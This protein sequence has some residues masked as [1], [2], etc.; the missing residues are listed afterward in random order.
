[1]KHI[2][3]RLLVVGAL[4]GG[5]GFTVLSA[6]AAPTPPALGGTGT[7]Q[8]PAPGQ[9]LIG[10]ASGTYTPAAITCNGNCSIATTSGGIAV[11][12]ANQTTLVIG[13]NG[14][15]IVQSGTN[16]TRN[17]RHDLRCIVDRSRDFP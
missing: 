13:T 2:L 6:S 15:S 11:N 12:V 7:S 17:P 1:M 5:I 8:I 16:A 9:T 14:V 4:V 10:N 3:A